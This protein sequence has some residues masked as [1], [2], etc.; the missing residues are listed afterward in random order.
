VQSIG[1]GMKEVIKGMLLKL[2]SYAN[3]LIQF[4]LST[5]AKNVIEIKAV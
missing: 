5:V 4:T 3:Q 1:I 2:R